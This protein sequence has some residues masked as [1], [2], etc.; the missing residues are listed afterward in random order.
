MCAGVDGARPARSRKRGEPL[1]ELRVRPA[2]FGDAER[3]AELATQLGYPSTPQQ[4]GARLGHLLPRDEHA[5]YVA[6]LG[7]GPVIG[8]VHVFVKHTAESDPQ[9][10]IGGL[11]VDESQRQRGVGKLL[12]RH[13]EQWARARGLRSVYLRSN[14]L[15][16]DAHAFYASLDYRVVKTQA[17][18]CKDF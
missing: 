7:A 16:K 4:V 14:V 1:S 15:R 9:A 8:W 18:F 2:T 12:M 6:E 3:V 13:A 5:V 10:E 17:V 11:V